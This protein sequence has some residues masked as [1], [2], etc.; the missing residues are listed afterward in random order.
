MKTLTEFSVFSLKKAHTLAESL[1]KDETFASQFQEK[2]SLEAEKAARMQHA[3]EAV[4]GRF[5]NL[6]R[7]IVWQGEKGP[8]KALEKDGLFFLAEYYP[9]LNDKKR[10]GKPPEG[11][12]RDK[13][14]RPR[15]KGP[16]KPQQRE[17]AGPNQAAKPAPKADG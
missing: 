13:G 1:T 5:E 16:R 12:G 3:L 14:R 8:E 17:T 15:R 2:L 10:G 6:K 7:V 9:P 4:G 11:K